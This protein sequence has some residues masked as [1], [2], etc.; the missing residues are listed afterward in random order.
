[1]IIIKLIKLYYHKVNF[2]ILENDLMLIKLMIKTG[3]CFNKLNN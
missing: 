1:M 3:P 2:I